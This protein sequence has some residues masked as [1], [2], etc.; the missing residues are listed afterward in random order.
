MPGKQHLIAEPGHPTNDNH[1]Y[2]DRPIAET[3]TN[4]FFTVDN[5]WTVQYWNKAA[6]KI[7]KVP[8]TDIIGNN[9]W[10]KFEGIIPIELFS[11]DQRAF[12]KDKPVHFHE[13]WGEMGAWFDVITYHCDNTL[14]V[15]FKSSKQPHAQLSDSPV[16]QLKTLTELYRFVTEITNDCLWEWNLLTHEIFWIDGGHKRIFGYQVENTLIP[17]SFWE[18][19]IHP[20]D[21]QQVL[22]SLKNTLAKKL[23][24]KWEINYRFKASNGNYLYVHD[25]GHLIRG[26]DGKVIRI[27]GA[28]QNITEKTLLEVKLANLRLAR[29]KEIT[30]AVFKAQ[31][32]E[33]ESIANV[34]NENLNQ[35]L[36]ATKW[37]IQ[38]AKTDRDKRDLCLENSFEYVSHVISEIRKIHKTL[39]VPNI[40][41]TG[42]F[43]NIK[44]LVADTNNKNMVHFKFIESGID[45]EE[46]LDKHMQLDIL[47]MVQELMKNVVKH[48]YATIAIITLSRQSGNLILTVADNGKGCKSITEK[49]GVGILNIKSRAELYGGTVVVN[50]KTGKGYTLKVVL[51]CFTAAC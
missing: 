39:V 19:C 9:L 40:Q 30:D 20:E 27:I 26:E 45:E 13:Y 43:E 49:K 16:E 31:E 14:S 33:R 44:T 48:A 12:L 3:L 4:G 38:L 23:S 7:L 37:N 51:P 50:S 41:I 35:I 17:Q 1:H 11:V 10:Q 36:V 25:R 8:A 47:R 24:V 46:D 21:K 2:P 29:Q 32:N 5:T 34:L 42:L 6:E 28:T 22:Q 15:S 18:Q